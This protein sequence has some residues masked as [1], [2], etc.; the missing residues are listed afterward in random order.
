MT[1][2]GKYNLLGIIA[3]PA[4]AV[5]AGAIATANGVW[6]AYGKTYAFLFGLNFVFML[7]VAL[8]SG[9]LLLWA[10]GDKSRW[11]AVVPTLLTAFVGAAWYLW[12]AVFPS[13]VAPG[14]Q[15][16]GVP[17]YLLNVAAVSLVVVL[18]LRLTGIVS[19]TA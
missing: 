12:S 15:F 9:L 10:A 13:A 16:I 4:A 19:K 5:L 7:V 18:L 17:Q 3:L 1:K 11:L 8:F 14:W 2:Q 6:E